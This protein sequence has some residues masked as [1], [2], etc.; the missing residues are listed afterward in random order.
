MWQRQPQAQARISRVTA[1][2]VP[3]LGF[4]GGCAS[5]SCSTAERWCLPPSADGRLAAKDCRP[6]KRSS[7]ALAVAAIISTHYL[8][9]S[10]TLRAHLLLASRQKLTCLGPLPLPLPARSAL[11]TLPALVKVSCG[12]SGN[13]VGPVADAPSLAIQDFPPLSDPCVLFPRQSSQ[14]PMALFGCART[15]RTTPGWQ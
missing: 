6:S 13:G 7:Q 14:A 15:A 2:E 8:K 5:A 10:W 4:L 12:V 11:N 9:S 3:C 1:S